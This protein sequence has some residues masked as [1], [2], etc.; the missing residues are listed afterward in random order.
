M[1]IEHLESL[2]TC[3]DECIGTLSRR[4]DIFNDAT[5]N[6]ASCIDSPNIGNLFS[7]M[8][9]IDKSQIS[10]STIPPPSPSTLQPPPRPIP[11]HWACVHREQGARHGGPIID[12]H[13]CRINQIH[14]DLFSLAARSYT[15][16][17]TSMVSFSVTHTQTHRH[18]HTKAHTHTHTQTHI[19]THTHTHTHTHVRASILNL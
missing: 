7:T 18:S 5:S 8:T 1:F 9:R 2:S 19:H 11:R 13:R 12:S 4:G 10:P 14:I 3:R 16:V 17:H 6:S 15:H